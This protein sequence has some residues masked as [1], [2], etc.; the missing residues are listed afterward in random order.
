L[1]RVLRRRVRESLTAPALPQAQVE[2]L[3]LLVR[4]PGIRAREVAESLGLASNTVSTLIQQLSLKGYITREI[5]SRDRR[6]ARISPTPAAVDRINSW[7]DK[8]AALLASAVDTLD[9][10]DYERLAACVPVLED[11]AGILERGAYDN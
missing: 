3:R 9:D 10:S 11:L 7:S 5:D 1:H 6:S 8:R 2:I 4:E